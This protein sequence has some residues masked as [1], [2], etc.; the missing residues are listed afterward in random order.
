MSNARTYLRKE[1]VSKDKAVLSVTQ[2]IRTNS[3]FALL[4]C[5]IAT[6]KYECFDVSSQD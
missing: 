3:L 5:F 6:Q 4:S 1:K 2:G